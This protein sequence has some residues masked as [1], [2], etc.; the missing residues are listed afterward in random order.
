M[1]I[2]IRVAIEADL[3]TLVRLNQVVQDVHAELYPKDFV[4]TVDADGLKAFLR[5]LLAEVAIA[6]L[7]SAPVGYIWFEVQARPASPFSPATR[8]LYVH[9]L[10]VVPEARRQGVAAALMSH[11]EAH[12]E[13]QQLDEIALS[14]WAANSGAHRFFAAQGF[15][16]YLLLLRK[17]LGDSGA[18]GAVD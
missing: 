1:S 10:S 9:H 2:V 11:A 7:G 3:D 12:A 13:S 17:K 14:H 18:D 4:A 15:A 8:R 5:P 16:P 6:E